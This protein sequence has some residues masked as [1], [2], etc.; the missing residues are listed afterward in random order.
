MAPYLFMNGSR[1]ARLVTVVEPG[2]MG[3]AAVVTDPFP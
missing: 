3:R 2:A 1:L